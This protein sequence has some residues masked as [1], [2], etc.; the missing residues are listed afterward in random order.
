MYFLKKRDILPPSGYSVWWDTWELDL[1]SSK[2]ISDP[3]VWQLASNSSWN[4]YQRYKYNS[5]DVEYV[6]H[7]ATI[8]GTIGRRLKVTINLFGVGAAYADFHPFPTISDY[9]H[10]GYLKTAH[11]TPYYIWSNGTYPVISRYYSAGL[12]INYDNT[13]DY[14]YFKSGGIWKSPIKDESGVYTPVDISIEAEDDDAYKLIYGTFPLGVYKNRN[15]KEALIGFVEFNISLNGAAPYS[16]TTTMYN[17]VTYPSD[18]IVSV[19]EQIPT[20]TARP[21]LVS[22]P[23]LYLDLSDYYSNGLFKTSQEYRIINTDLSYWSYTGILPYNEDMSDITFTRHWLGEG[24]DPY[25]FS[26]TLSFSNYRNYLEADSSKRL[27]AY[28]P[29][30][31]N[32]HWQ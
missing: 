26:L 13:A 16:A 28:L 4:L 23:S 27:V 12:R 9:S 19:D 3:T 15:D 32:G 25:P 2:V 11:A 1:L 7:N 22:G 31:D 29:I 6:L 18:R 8:P 5:S 20:I 24:S 17:Y 10:F 14:F 21:S 30:I